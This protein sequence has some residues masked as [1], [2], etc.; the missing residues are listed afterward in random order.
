M[1]TSQN[2]RIL[3][4]IY[5]QWQGGDI[6]I[7]F[8]DLSVSEAARGYILGAEILR[9]LTDSIA[10]QYEKNT[11]VVQIEREFMH[12]SA[13]KR[14]AND[15]IIDKEVLMRQSQSAF[16]ILQ[17]KKPT[18]ILTLGGE[19]ASS[20]PPFSYLASLYKDEV[21]LVWID[22]HPDIGLPHDEFYQG[23]HAMA[24]SALLG[25]GGLKEAFNLQGIL[26][27]NK[28]LLVG[29]HSKEAEHYAQ[30]QKEFGLKSLTPEEVAK[31]SNKVLEFLQQ[32]GAKKVMIHLDLDVL[33]PNEL[34]VAVGNTGKMKIEQVSRVINDIAK[35]YEV[36]GLTIAEHLPKAQIKLKELLRDLPLIKD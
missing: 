11:A 6:A 15:G 2:N 1:H 26:E 29:L 21:A 23:Y 5:P 4:L 34:Y 31:D 27:S 30:R 19:C 13:G 32:S 10:P 24:V 8:D 14:I 20:V 28:V 16:R 3:R 18:K 9:I 35:D 33:D 17:D 7:W 12:D 25:K 22:A 36:V